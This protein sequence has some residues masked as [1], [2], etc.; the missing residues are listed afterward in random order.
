MAAESTKPLVAPTELFDVQTQAADVTNRGKWND[1]HRIIVDDG[2]SLTYSTTANDT[3][4]FPWMTPTSVPRVGA[5]I[6][7]PAPVILIKDFS[8]WRLL[9]SSQVVGAP[10]AT[11]PQFSRPGRPTLAPQNVGGDVKLATFNVLNFF[12]THGNEYEAADLNNHCTYFTDRQGNQITTNACGNPA[13]TSGNGPRGAANA[14]NVARQ[15]DKIVSA[16]N[17]AD[18]DIVSLEELENSAKFGK[19]RDFAITELV[20][21]LNA[22][23]TP[24]QVGVRSRRRRAATCRP[25]PTR[26]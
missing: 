6:T 8:A 5:A 3:S 19:P 13:T 1:A 18:A 10:T 15:R 14:A 24:G 16:I 12:P 7:F 11:Q 23:T 26:T 21:A 4:P 22:A 9:P 17:T 20:T 25:W 2:S